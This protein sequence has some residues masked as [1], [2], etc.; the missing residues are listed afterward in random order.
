MAALSFSSDGPSPALSRACLPR[1]AELR[2]RVPGR[3]FARVC[4]MLGDQTEQR[5]VLR[6]TTQIPV[7]APGVAG[8]V[9]AVR[10]IVADPPVTRRPP[11]V[12]EIGPAT[13]AHQD[14]CRPAT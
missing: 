5:H 12:D 3:P 2:A 11:A 14:H 8:L 13:R 10:G 9:I 7:R 4:E 1:G 6:R